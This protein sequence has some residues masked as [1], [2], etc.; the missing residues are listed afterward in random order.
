MQTASATK[1]DRPFSAAATWRFI[2]IKRHARKTGD[3]VCSPTPARVTITLRY[4][5]PPKLWIALEGG[6][7]IVIERSQK[8]YWAGATIPS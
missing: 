2:T 1:H 7:S 5:N 8:Y 6:K 4:I 3:R